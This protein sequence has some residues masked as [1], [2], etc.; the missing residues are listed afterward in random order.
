MP[1]FPPCIISL[2]SSR[3]Y[4]HEPGAMAITDRLDKLIGF[5][6][7]TWGRALEIAL[8]SKG[9]LKEFIADRHCQGQVELETAAS[10]HSQ[11]SGCLMA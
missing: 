9:I 5:Q 2:R 11:T 10:L 4:A 6:Q 8:K 1:A 3:T 7:M